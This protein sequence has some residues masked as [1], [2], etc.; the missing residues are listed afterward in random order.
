MDQEYV[1]FFY[2][3]VERLQFFVVV[4]HHIFWMP[5]V[6]GKMLVA[7]KLNVTPLLKPNSGV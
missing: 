7:F 5:P 2:D 4:A 6:A 3:D 1:Q